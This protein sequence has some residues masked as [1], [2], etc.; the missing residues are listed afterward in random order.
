MT[1]LLLSGNTKSNKELQSIKEDI[2]DTFG[3]N[4]AFDSYMEE[5]RKTPFS[6]LYFRLDSTP[7]EV[8]LNFKDKL[9]PK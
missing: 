9:Y 7:P 5:A 4:A 8:Y 2:A 3:G 1:G 6:W